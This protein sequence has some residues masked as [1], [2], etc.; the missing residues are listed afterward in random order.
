[1]RFDCEII[2]DMLPLYVDEVCSEESK[3]TVEAHLLGCESC[4]NAL[5]QMRADM[6]KG[7]MPDFSEQEVLK[8]ATWSISK[9]AIGA[10]VGVVTIIVYWLVYF[11]EETLSDMGDYRYFS[12]EFHEIYSVGYFLVPLLTL[13]WLVWLL[14]RS[15]ETCAW[16]RNCAL[17]IVLG[18]LL[19]GQSSIWLQ[20][21]ETTYVSCVSEVVEIPDQYH[22][23]IET[24]KGY[25][26]LETTPVVIK[27]LE[28]D[29]TRYHFAY[30]YY[31]DDWDSG[32]LHYAE[33]MAN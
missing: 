29:G 11:W 1:M 6:H 23:V 16:R 8:K 21:G 7:N 27:L 10:A 26:T 33:H 20:Y 5:E 17:L 2:L 19:L 25:V 32:T 13:G 4:R 14:I 24:T 28:M 31:R 15:R 9:R 30:H 3:K 12:Y 18:V 22:V